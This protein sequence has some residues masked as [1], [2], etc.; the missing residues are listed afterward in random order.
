GTT[1]TTNWN[2]PSNGSPEWNNLLKTASKKEAVFFGVNSDGFFKR[3]AVILLYE[4]NSKE[5]SN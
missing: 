3:V 1:G 4:A 2:Q 5:M